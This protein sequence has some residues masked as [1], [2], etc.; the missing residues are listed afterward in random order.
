MTSDPYQPSRHHGNA[1]TK[2]R[3][4]AAA[5]KADGENTE[6]ASHTPSCFLFRPRPPALQT[7]RP[8]TPERLW[9]AC[10]HQQHR[11]SRRGWFLWQRESKRILSSSDFMLVHLPADGRANEV[12][13]ATDPRLE[14]G[15]LCSSE[16][17]SDTDTLYM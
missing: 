13:V 7:L 12:A 4:A 3:R 17:V 6:T 14:P 2:V 15:Y 11:W 5:W 1:Q 16:P 10:L 8:P 9:R